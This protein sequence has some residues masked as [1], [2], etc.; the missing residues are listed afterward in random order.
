[1]G[2]E[3]A[4]TKIGIRYQRSQGAIAKADKSWDSEAFKF[5]VHAVW[6]LLLVS[7]LRAVCIGWKLFEA[8]AALK[9]KKA[10]L[11]E[12]LASAQRLPPAWEVIVELEKQAKGELSQKE[13]KKL[14]KR[15]KE[16]GE[17]KEVT[18]GSDSEEE[19]L[20]EEVRRRVKEAREEKKNKKKR[21]LA[22]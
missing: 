8:S 6:D 1:M 13:R 10:D 2:N 7:D 3:K 4:R 11:L 22:P 12:K 5:A 15:M 16:L 19:S 17:Q 20:E 9:A 18:E 14:S 21:K